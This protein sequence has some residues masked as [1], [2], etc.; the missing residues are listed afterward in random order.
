M[1]IRRL[2]IF[3]LSL[4]CAGRAF[5]DY[6]SYHP[7]SVIKLGKAFDAFSPD[8]D[9]TNNGYIVW[10]SYK[11]SQEKG[12]DIE[13]NIHEVKSR[14]E[15]YKNLSIDLAAESKFAL[16]KGSASFSRISQVNFD[17][18]TVNY[19]IQARKTFKPII[20]SGELSLSDNGLKRIKQAVEESKI[21]RF[22]QIVGSE[23]VTQI[24]KGAQ[25]SVIYSFKASSKTKKDSI[26]AAINA[27]WKS[28]SASANMLSEVEK[29]DSGYSLNLTAIQTGA[30]EDG[31]TIENLIKSKPGDLG[32]VKDVIE[33]A[34]KGVDFESSKILGFATTKIEDIDDIAWEAGDQLSG[35]SATLEYITRINTELY[36]TYSHINSK[37]SD[38]DNLLTN[39]KD[40]QLN[41][42]AKDELIKLKNLF[43]VEREKLVSSFVANNKLS[44]NISSINKPIV[45]PPQ[46]SA[47]DY[48]KKPFVKADSWSR[49]NISACRCC[50]QHDCEFHDMSLNFTLS[51]DILHP[52]FIDK[53]RIIKNDQGVGIIRPKDFGR[54]LAG[55]G[56]T[57]FIYSSNHSQNKVYTWGDNNVGAEKN[58]WTNNFTKTEQN[59]S[60]VLEVTDTEGNVHKIDIGCY[61]KERNTLI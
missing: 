49:S 27:T 18:R 42:D 59:S 13:V 51:I 45:N 50:S 26:R 29:S 52:E 10:K 11:E 58:N 30:N 16:G 34:V 55:N 9:K 12:S 15:L 33:K 54:I 24:T 8:S 46:F 2:V 6:H 61:G 39:K 31:T 1:G 25:V 17:E 38:I 35:I 47:V 48:L 28:G 22:R 44:N 20:T 7:K 3:A 56:S 53:I 5:A 36:T 60:Y 57:S 19:V 14:S 21:I 43:L 32:Y 40:A 37:L 23:I 4:V 41:K